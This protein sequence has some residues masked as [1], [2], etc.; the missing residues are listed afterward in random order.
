[1]SAFLHRFRRQPGADRPGWAWPSWV[2]LTERRKLSVA[3]AARKPGERS[4]PPLRPDRREIR[5]AA[6]LKQRAEVAERK[7]IRE[8]EARASAEE[9]LRDYLGPLMPQDMQ[10][11]WVSL[12]CSGSVLK[13]PNRLTLS[14]FFK[15]RGQDPDW[16]QPLQSESTA[17]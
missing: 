11:A 7:A 17:D 6:R 15:L 5:K 10:D 14:R 4:G 2:P 3:F 1:M 8:A 13:L 9:I 16:W 12:L